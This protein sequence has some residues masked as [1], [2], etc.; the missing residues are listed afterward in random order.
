MNKYSIHKCP[1]KSGCICDEGTSGGFDWSFIDTIFCIC[2]KDRNDRL[3]HSV[4]QF[5]KY[6]L[7]KKVIYYR[8][9]RP[10]DEVVQKY[11][12]KEKGRYGCWEAH[13]YVTWLAKNLYQSKL[14]LIFEDDVLFVPSFSPETLKKIRHHI[15]VQLPNKWD[16]YYLG[17][18][19]V[20]GNIP[21]G[22]NL[23]KIHGL[24]SHAYIQNSHFIDKFINMPW[25]EYG[26]IDNNK[27]EIGPD[28]WAMR[29]AK[30]YAYSPMIAVQNDMSSDAGV[31]S[32]KKLYEKAIV[33][34]GKHPIFIEFIFMK[35]IYILL[36]IALVFLLYKN[37]LAHQYA[38]AKAKDKDKD[39]GK[40]KAKSNE[41][42][43][44]PAFCH[45]QN[46]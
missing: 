11:N 23:W 44:L 7:C 9:D 38:K 6:G 26:R 21:C 1:V 16:V 2:L 43:K 3:N 40:D 8:P 22:N 13:R 27:R 30:Q 29:N 17:Y 5:H 33:F 37:I 14:N 28:S 15:E 34:H 24:M 45:V 18:M 32:Y 46:R 36:F 12:L 42:V 35:L 31:T 39:K 41:S 25:I 4:E 10:S 19:P 20:Y